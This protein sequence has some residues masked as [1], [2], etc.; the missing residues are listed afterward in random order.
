M[1]RRLRNCLEHGTSIDSIQI[2]YGERFYNTTTECSPRF[3]GLLFNIGK[4]QIRACHQRTAKCSTKIQVHYPVYEAYCFFIGLISTSM[5]ACVQQQLM[6]KP[7]F[8]S[9][10]T[11]F[12]NFYL[13]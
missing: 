7:H 5:F 2:I 11:H 4:Y 6:D 3:N 9:A 1:V 12:R 13:G 10:L 8:F